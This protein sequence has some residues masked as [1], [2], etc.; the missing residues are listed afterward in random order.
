[1]IPCFTYVEKS[2][3][4]GKSTGTGFFMIEMKQ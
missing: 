3:L 2:Q 1:M 4:I